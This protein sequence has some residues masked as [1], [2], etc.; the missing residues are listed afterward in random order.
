MNRIKKYLKPNSIKKLRK[1]LDFRKKGLIKWDRNLKTAI[2]CHEKKN[3]WTDILP[4]IMLAIRNM[5]R[6]DIGISPVEMIYGETLS[7]PTNLFTQVE[8]TKTEIFKFTRK[9]KK[10]NELRPI[11]ARKHHIQK[12]FIFKNIDTCT[13]AL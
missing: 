5:Q 13:R 6:D 8:D 11:K 3:N 12:L 10:I 9:L 2:T 1:F 4:I 7:L